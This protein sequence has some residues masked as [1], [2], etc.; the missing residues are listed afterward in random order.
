MN[1]LKYSRFPDIL[2]RLKCQQVAIDGERASYLE[3]Y[4]RYLGAKSYVIED[5]YIDAGYLK[6]YAAYY[7]MRG[8]VARKTTRLHFFTRESAEIQEGFEY[9][10]DRTSDGD[11]DDYLNDAYLGFVVIRPL[12]ETVIGRS[13]LRAY[14]AGADDAN[15]SW[16]RY[17]PLLRKYQVTLAGMR[18]NVR[19]VAFQEQDN[20]IAACS[21]TAIWHALH[22][23]PHRITAQQ[24]E[25]LFEISNSASKT[26]HRMPA[27]GE[28]AHRFPTTGL[29]AD[30]IQGYL[31]S[32][33]LECLVRGFSGMTMSTGLLEY[34][35]TFCAAGFPLILVGRLHVSE[36]RD[37]DYGPHELH[38]V[39]VLGFSE[40]LKK[41][42]PGAASEKI[43]K[44]YVHDDTLGPFARYE[45][46]M[47]AEKATFASYLRSQ[48]Q[49][50]MSRKAAQHLH[51][52][53]G[54]KA[55]YRRFLPV[56]AI[57][58]IDGGVKYPYENVATFATTFSEL[59]RSQLDT[60]Q[61]AGPRP[62][63]EWAV[64]LLH[65]TEF[66]VSLRGADWLDADVRADLL[67]RSLDYVWLAEFCEINPAT[68]CRERRLTAIFDA[69][70]LRQEGSV[71]AIFASGGDVRQ[72]SY[73]ALLAKTLHAWDAG[74]NRKTF[75]V[76]IHPAMNKIA[77]VL[78]E[79]P[80]IPYAPADDA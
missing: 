1:V 63:V 73:E 57:I 59:I 23:L 12:N 33:G 30:Q 56:Y 9:F 8:D 55:R 24:I 46:A 42:S 39:T 20:E 17:F 67:E 22:A 79:D 18:L 49:D 54:T 27:L 7:S 69:N 19:S 48:Y 45:V 62:Q 5:G 10:W 80:P 4:L 35:H 36:N 26:D 34:V 6:D 31:Q 40:S 66:K 58:P 74:K 76:S 77:V 78:K 50:D 25:S 13:C 43:G 68:Q 21:A 47:P 37:R 71:I 72:A 60:G 41:T 53:T 38:A 15:G 16:Y 61:A 14:G 11:V 65:G 52:G 64:K 2:A 51:T 32:K 70:Q 3:T 28:A 29:N 75:P 44:I